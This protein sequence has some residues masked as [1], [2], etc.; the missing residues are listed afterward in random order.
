M[1]CEITQ[2]F[3]LGCRSN[4][5]GIRNVYILSGSVSGVT[6][7]NGAI[8]DI[9]GSGVFYKFEMPRNVG[10]LTE[11]PV[12]SLENGTVYYT[13]VVNMT[14][15]KMQAS[16]RNQVKVLGQNP[17]IKIIVETENGADDYVG[18]FFYVGQERG[19]TLTGGSGAS[20]TAFG[21]ANQ[22]ALTFEANEPNPMQEIT[23]TGDLEDALS[24]ITV[25]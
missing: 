2:G 19:S 23:T 13:Q 9:A 17:N 16:V 7:A 14:M 6:A 5:G 21:D 3:T 18:K 12:P 22:Y 1:A 10:D 20:G 8:S 15:H 11:T 25:S 4:L 24:G